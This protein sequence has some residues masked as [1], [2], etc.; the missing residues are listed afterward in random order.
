M[1]ERC[2]LIRVRRPDAPHEQ[3]PR[4]DL[5]PGV[6]GSVIGREQLVDAALRAGPL[7]LAQH[8]LLYLS[9]GR[10]GQRPK[11]ALA[12]GRET[13]EEIGSPSCIASLSAT[14]SPYLNS[15]CLPRERSGV[16][17]PVAPLPRPQ[18]VRADVQDR[19]RFARP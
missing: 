10:L 7:G 17:E 3:R 14:T 5:G 13:A 6:C 18:R 16:R 2:D 8:E 4:R 9:G 1:L 15:R 19:D 12:G 11:Q